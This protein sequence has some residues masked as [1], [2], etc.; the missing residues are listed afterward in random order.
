VFALSQHVTGSAD[1]FGYLGSDG[2]L[3]YQTTIRIPI[4]LSRTSAVE[5][6]WQ[7]QDYPA[8]GKGGGIK[9]IQ[10]PA[11]GKGGRAVLRLTSPYSNL[12]TP[13]LDSPLDHLLTNR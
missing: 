6:G 1:A 7:N 2:I 12:A 5:E 8:A 3:L 4:K 11:V 13:P 9:T 10:N